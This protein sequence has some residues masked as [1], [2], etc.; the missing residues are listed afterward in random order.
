[1]TSYDD[2][3]DDPELEEEIEDEDAECGH[4]L[5]DECGGCWECGTC[6]C[7]EEDHSGQW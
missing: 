5:C 2:L 6:D 7:Y 3:M 4:D 1:M